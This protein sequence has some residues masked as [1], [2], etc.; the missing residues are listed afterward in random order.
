MVVTDAQ[1]KIQS[2]FDLF[3]YFNYRTLRSNSYILIIGHYSFEDKFVKMNS[4]IVNY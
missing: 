4:K 3:K 1:T 2:P